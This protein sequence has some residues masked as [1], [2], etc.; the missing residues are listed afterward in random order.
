MARTMRL[1]DGNEIEVEPVGFRDQTEPWASYLLDDGSV[2][3]VKLVVTEIFRVVGQYDPIGNPSYIVN[4]TNVMNVSSPDELRRE[5]G[6]S[7]E[8]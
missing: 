1:P 6:E 2:V 3:R 4:S 7:P 8:E 5:P